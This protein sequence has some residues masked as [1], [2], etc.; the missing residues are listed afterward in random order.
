[1][2]VGISALL[3][4]DV[5]PT[6]KESAT[7]TRPA[8]SQASCYILA[9]IAAMRCCLAQALVERYSGVQGDTSIE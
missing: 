1:M 6:S 7:G 9:T 5:T 8:C 3:T 4:L 2:H